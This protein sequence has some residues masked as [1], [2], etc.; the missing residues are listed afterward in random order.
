MN[1]RDAINI[2]ASVAPRVSTLPVLSCLALK[3]DGESLRV[4][5]GG[6]ELGV[7]AIAE[8]QSDAFECC[9][10]AEKL[11]KAVGSMTEPKLSFKDNRL[12]VREGKTRAALPTL[13]YSMHPGLPT[14]SKPPVVATAEIM[15]LVD[16]VAFAAAKKDIRPFLNGVL[17]TCD[18][19]TLTT[20]ATDGH[21]MAIARTEF[22][23]EPFQA[24]IPASSV[25]ALASARPESFI[26]GSCLTVKSGDLTLTTKLIDSRYPDV[27]RLLPSHQKR[28]TVETAKLRHAVQMVRPFC[29]DKTP[30]VLLRWG[31]G[32]LTIEARNGEGAESSAEI[33]CEC[34]E[35]GEIGVNANYLDDAVSAIAAESVSIEYGDCNASIRMN[36][37]DTS[38]IVMPM[39]L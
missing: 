7:S 34:D 24:I 26:F 22:V 6:I 38:H 29:N 28:L 21:R 5:G 19:Q 32:T 15:A 27:N 1:L 3:A 11:K 39:R 17:V 35:S 36:D 33:D 8:Y 2:A 9:V 37:G 16:K 12:T 20:C 14:E 31:D 13:E 18:G 4:V 25:K 23:S 30:G 10:D